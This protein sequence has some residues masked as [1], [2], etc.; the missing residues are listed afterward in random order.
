MGGIIYRGPGLTIAEAIAVTP[1]ARITPEDSGLWEDHQNEPF[2]KI[3]EFAHSQSQYV[4][5]R[6]GRAGRKAITVAPWIDRKASAP[7]EAGG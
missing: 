6:L 5:I 1:E 2:E 7:V 4:G 3:T